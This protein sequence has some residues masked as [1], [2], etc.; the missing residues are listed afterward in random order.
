MDPC[1][2]KGTYCDALD[3]VLC[4]AGFNFRWL[5]RTIARPGP[6]CNLHSHVLA[7]FDP[8]VPPNRAP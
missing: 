1:W 7:G 8:V 6:A 4:A 5:L 3:A 2:L